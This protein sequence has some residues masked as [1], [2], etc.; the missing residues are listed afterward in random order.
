[1]IGPEDGEV[2]SDYEPGV[3]EDDVALSDESDATKIQKA[4]DELEG[5]SLGSFAEEERVN[6][7]A[8]AAV[9]LTINSSIAIHE[10]PE[11]DEKA[12]AA[13]VEGDATSIANTLEQCL[14]SLQPIIAPD[15]STNA[16]ESVSPDMFNFKS[17]INLQF[18]H[19]RIQAKTGV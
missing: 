13:A 6:N 17:L 15:E 3:D 2:D 11:L 10:L 4:L 14:M 9:S 18:E 1:M 19:Q 7:L 16:F 8:F 5:I 12:K